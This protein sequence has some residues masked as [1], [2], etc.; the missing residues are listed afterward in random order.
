MG[1][2]SS[3]LPAT[4]SKGGSKTAA[5]ERA[6]VGASRHAAG[7]APACRFR[8]KVKSVTRM[9]T[10]QRSV[11]V[12][13]DDGT[14]ESFIMPDACT[15]LRKVDGSGAALAE[16]RAPPACRRFVPPDELVN[17]LLCEYMETT[18]R[19]SL[20]RQS[21][22]RG[23]KGRKALACALGLESDLGTDEAVAKQ[24]Y[25]PSTASDSESRAPA[26]P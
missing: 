17:D 3:T 26:P 1:S 2:A 16:G 6:A 9:Q 22:L 7:C 15:E 18:Q 12:L 5:G 23:Y 20:T 11:R 21:L 25:G 8:G 4:R 13:F 24:E 10:N 14:E 19:A